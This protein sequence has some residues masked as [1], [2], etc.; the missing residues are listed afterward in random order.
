MSAPIFFVLKDKPEI[1]IQLRWVLSFLTGEFY[2]SFDRILTYFKKYRAFQKWAIH[3]IM[4]AFYLLIIESM[5]VVEALESGQSTLRAIDAALV[6]AKAGLDKDSCTKVNTT[7]II[8]IIILVVIASAN[9]FVE[10]E[11]LSLK[12]NWLRLDN[13]WRSV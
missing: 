2:M 3:W 6:Q 7:S 1:M 9:T 10:G 8:D 11:T 12:S 13:Y 4:S 5:A